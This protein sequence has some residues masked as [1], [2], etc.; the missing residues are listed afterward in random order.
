MAQLKEITL[1]LEITVPVEA[2]PVVKKGTVTAEFRWSMKKAFK[3]SR[4]VS[5]LCRKYGYQMLLEGS[6]D[7]L[8]NLCDRQQES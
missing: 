6:K 7:D 8:Q 1:A 3:F 5:K 4:K 2:K